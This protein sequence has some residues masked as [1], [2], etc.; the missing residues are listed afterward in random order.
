[1][2]FEELVKQR[3]SIRK[4]KPDS[5][6]AETLN[7]IL[8]V[9]AY[10][11]HKRLSEKYR[12]V[13]VTNRDI[14]E[15]MRTACIETIEN[16]A[17]KWTSEDETNW[18][19]LGIPFPKRDRI[20]ASVKDHYL[21]FSKRFD[22]FFGDAP[23]VL[24]LA[25]QAPLWKEAP[26]VW[27]ILQLVGA[28]MQSVQLAAAERGIGSCSM[29]GPLHSRQVHAR[30][31]QLES[32]WEIVAIL[33][34]GYPERM[35]SARPRKPLSEVLRWIPHQPSSAKSMAEVT[36]QKT[37]SLRQACFLEVL[38]SRRNV[39][40]F[41]PFPVP[42]EEIEQIIDLVRLSPN[43]LNQQKWRFL[44]LSDREM[45]GKIS[46]AMIAKASQV[47]DRARAGT[48]A[49]PKEMAFLDTPDAPEAENLAE[50]PQAWLHF[51]TE[52]AQCLSKAPALVAVCNEALPFGST[53]DQWNDIESIGCAVETLMLEAAVR[54]Y[55]SA[56]MTSPLIAWQEVDRILGV[57]DPWRTVSLVP[58]GVEIS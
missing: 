6:P 54:G 41:L 53:Y 56:W 5:I 33:P 50:N 38:K 23:V 52:R 22:T 48:Q 27:P 3:R 26:H 24:V 8:E 32:P 31:L 12:V 37:N 17:V 28:V 15:K 43:A 20:G 2:A 7:E 10:P 25:T 13:P 35:P 55:S 18:A 57:Q 29:T 36:P 45:L 42:H 47:T 44:A 30:L 4:F 49:L 16:R 9:T 58:L 21:Y 1:M 34:L 46:E 51:L 11:A 39:Y 14:I 19:S 40:N